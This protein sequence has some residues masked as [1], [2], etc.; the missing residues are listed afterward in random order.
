MTCRNFFGLTLCLAV[1]CAAKSPSQAQQSLSDASRASVQKP[2][3]IGGGGWLVGLDIAAD[4]QRLARTDTYGAYI[5]NSQTATWSQLVTQSRMPKE[6]FGFFP[7]TGA[8]QLSQ[9]AGGVYEIAAAPNS[10]ETIYMVYNGFV[11]VSTNHGETFSKTNFHQVKLDP[12]GQYRMNGRKLAVDPANSRHAYLGTE[13]NG[14]FETEDGDHWTKVAGVPIATADASGTHYPSYNIAFD[15]SSGS[16]NGKT[17]VVYAFAYVNEGGVPKGRMY[18]SNDSGR[19]WNA[20]GR[21]PTTMDH[22]VVAPVGGNVWATDSKNGSNG[23]GGNLWTYTSGTWTLVAAAGSNN[24]AVAVNPAN[25]SNALCVTAGGNL[26]VSANGGRSW[27]GSVGFTQ[28]AKDVPWLGWAA[29]A[30]MAAGDAIFDP[31]LPGQLVLG[32]GIGVWSTTIPT[33]GGAT[34]WTSQTAGIEQLVTTDGIAPNGVPVVGV[35]DRATFRLAD[36]DKYPVTTNTTFFNAFPLTVT[37]GIDYASSNPNFMAALITTS[38][39]NAGNNSGWSGD[40]GYTWFPFNS[41]YQTVAASAIASSDGTGS[42]Q[43]KITVPS[44]AGLITWGQGAGSI[45]RIIGYNGNYANSLWPVTVNDETHLT[46]QG[47][48]FSNFN[49]KTGNYLIY[50]PTMPLSDFNFGYRIRGISNNNG[51]VRITF[52]NT[53]QGLQNGDPLVITGVEGA[54]EANG[55]WIAANVNNAT[56]S[57]DLFGSL[58]QHTWTGGGIGKTTIPRGGY[59]A[60]STAKNVV[61]V[62]SNNDYPYVTTN[63]GQTWQQKRFPQGIGAGKETGWGFAYYTNRHTAVADRVTPNTFY[64]YNYLSGIYKLT[65]GEDP[66]L[67]SG[68]D[69]AGRSPGT[70]TA[71][72]FPSSTFNAKLKSVPGKAGHLFFTAGPQGTGGA[73]HPAPTLLYR[74]KNGGASWTEIPNVAEPIAIDLGAVAPGRS[75]PTLY[76]VGWVHNEYGVWRSVDADERRPSWT[77]VASYPLGSMDFV[78]NIIADGVTWNKWYMGWSGSGYTFGMEK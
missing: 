58:Y 37:Y 2:L 75:Y 14:L 10:P 66:V 35:L 38:F 57:A 33:S 21:G 32:A 62:A 53:Y 15:P 25:A 64:M 20:T 18:V 55:S 70:P 29:D 47:T 65:G 73:Y 60:A 34:V 12:N 19:T 48:R 11:F 44:T 43:V 5:W 36:P 26:N 54:A 24:H 59:I 4:G 16:S 39:G 63:G 77:K 51:L 40:G 67:V 27:S 42:G 1:L 69:L 17:N 46:L 74:S 68:T 30:Y 9:S 8:R 41:Y 78:S 28:V 7:S 13:A 31:S 3:K 49:N 56:N 72:L 23:A 6:S 50:V 45:L 71:N 61:V 76:M 52:A 22:M